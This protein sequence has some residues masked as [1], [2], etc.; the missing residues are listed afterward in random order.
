MRGRGEGGYGGGGRR[1]D[2]F[3][4]PVDLAYISPPPEAD[5]KTNGLS[6]RSCKTSPPRSLPP[7]AVLPSPPDGDLQSNANVKH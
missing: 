3:I 6:S 7:P 2:S 1:M 4:F 5:T